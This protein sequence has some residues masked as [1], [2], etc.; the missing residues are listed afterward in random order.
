ML[1]GR[2]EGDVVDVTFMHTE[3][4]IDRQRARGRDTLVGF[5]GHSIVAVC[6]PHESC[7]VV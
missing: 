6:P 5:A 1:I 3:R 4:E 7:R 2:V